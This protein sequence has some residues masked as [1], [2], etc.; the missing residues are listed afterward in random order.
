[1]RRIVSAVYAINRGR[2][3]R[4]LTI[5]STWVRLV[6]SASA[7]GAVGARLNALLAKELETRNPGAA[8]RGRVESCIELRNRPLL[9]AGEWPS[10]SLTTLT[11]APASSNSRR[12]NPDHVSVVS[13]SGGQGTL[14]YMAKLQ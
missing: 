1:M 12:V 2:A 5:R 7:G 14:Q 9:R 4:N 10:R 13:M 3:R 11:G 8:P 6:V